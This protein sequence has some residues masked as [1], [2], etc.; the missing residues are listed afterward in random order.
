[1]KCSIKLKKKNP[2]KV[3]IFD[4]LVTYNTCILEQIKESNS[5]ME[6]KMGKL[7]YPSKDYS[8]KMAYH[9]NA[10]NKGA[11]FFHQC[12]KEKY[13][14][15]CSSEIQLEN[16]AKNLQTHFSDEVYLLNQTI[17]DLGF[18]ETVACAKI[19][20]EQLINKFG[21]THSSFFER[22]CGFLNTTSLNLHKSWTD[23]YNSSDEKD[24]VH[25]ILQLLISNTNNMFIFIGVSDIS[26]NLDKKKNL[27]LLF[28]EKIKVN[29]NFIKNLYQQLLFKQNAVSIEEFASKFNNVENIEDIYIYVISPKKRKTLDI[30]DFE[31]YII[32]PGTNELSDNLENDKWAKILLHQ[33][34][35]KFLNERI[36]Q[37]IPNRIFVML[38]TFNF[39]QNIF[40][41]PIDRYRFLL[42]G[43]SIKAAL[44]LRDA[45]D[46]DFLVLDHDD[47]IEKYGSLKPN[48]GIEGIFDDFGKTFY[49]NEE[50]YFPMIPEMYQ[51]QLELKTKQRQSTTED[52]K[53]T[54]KTIV[55]NF[56]PYSASGLKIGRYFS[57][58]RELYLPIINETNATLENLD[59]IILSPNHYVY[60]CGCKLIDIRIELMRDIIKDIDLGRVSKKQMHDFDLFANIYQ[61]ILT[62][63]EINTLRFKKYIDKKY[64]IYRAAEV[65]LQTNLYHEKFE[66]DEKVG[67]SVMIK[68]APHYLTTSTKIIIDNGPLIKSDNDEEI[69]TIRPRYDEYYLNVILSSLPSQIN[70]G[71][72]WLECNSKGEFNIY[73]NREDLQQNEVIS[74]EK[75][76]VYYGQLHITENS[77][78]KKYKFNLVSPI[79]ECIMD[80]IKESKKE[81]YVSIA[82]FVKNTIQMH[83]LIDCHTKTKILV[84][85][86]K[87]KIF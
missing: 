39:W 9:K 61:H 22:V 21:T 69:V 84:E 23:V 36:H 30:S 12:F 31:K 57:V 19:L 85:F 15:L 7:S 71:Q 42:A 80:K 17:N 6:Y 37:L 33:N 40:I 46:I 79:M 2:D 50:Y 48:I 55:N 16:I 70:D 77:I 64:D 66:S 62:E 18:Q 58:F 87:D 67:Y 65:K 81:Y 26:K 14:P 25:F 82:N 34:N 43:S 73:L 47:H 49:A 4:E 8:R 54:M 5:I 45:Q 11:S 56:P 63:T 32:G 72:Y 51:K 78:S 27:N 44:G 20:I 83:K 68:H 74:I 35:R 75:Y 13:M 52:H 29:D 1:M 59:D 53:P 24:I 76:N 60:F 41:K 28:S 38:R 10:E 3:S 86:T